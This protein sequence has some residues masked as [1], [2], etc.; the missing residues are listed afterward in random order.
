MGDQINE[1][2]F[3]LIHLFQCLVSGLQFSRSQA[4]NA[5]RNRKYDLELEN[6]LLELRES[7]F[8]EI[9]D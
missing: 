2:R 8:V 4:E 9:K 6:W 1:D 5:L 7:A 3:V